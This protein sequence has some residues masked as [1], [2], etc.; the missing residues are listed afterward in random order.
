MCLLTPA[1][2]PGCRWGGSGPMLPGLYLIPVDVAIPQV[3][4]QRSFQRLENLPVFR[5]Q[6]R[7]E[8]AAGGQVQGAS[9]AGLQGERLNPRS[10]CGH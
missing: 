3:A 8:R 6:D 10:F 5:A 9:R 2:V 7:I 1:A 4:L